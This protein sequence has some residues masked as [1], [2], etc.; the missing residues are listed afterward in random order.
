MRFEPSELSS[1]PADTIL[2]QVPDAFIGIDFLVSKSKRLPVVALDRNRSL[3][4][5]RS[6]APPPPKG[7]GNVATLE[8]RN[9]RAFAGEIVAWLQA[10]PY[11]IER[12]AI[13][14]PCNYCPPQLKRR[15]AER[16]LDRLGISCFATPTK[17]QFR[18]KVKTCKEFL[19]A[20][21]KANYLPNANQL[22]ML[23]GFQLF[24]ALEAEGIEAVEVFP[25]ATIKKLG[26]TLTHKTTADG[27]GEQLQKA[28]ELM[29]MPADTF[30]GKLQ[31]A[32]C[33]SR[34]KHDFTQCHD[35]LDAFFSAWVAALPA[36][37]R[38]VLGGELWIPRAAREAL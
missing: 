26:C 34:P 30:E 32:A 5:L 2:A 15:T 33:A 35:R 38:E 14:A 23:A 12:V 3:L 22:W 7:I 37:E 8:E 21:G 27:Y 31:Q 20:G 16:G 28:A 17:K 1:I 10:L 11:A 13:D 25:H 36:N 4:P 24:R 19:A 29:E 6:A 18:E 9:C